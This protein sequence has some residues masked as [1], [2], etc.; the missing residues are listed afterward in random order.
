V[1]GTLH[2]KDAYAQFISAYADITGL[3]EGDAQAQ[4][5]AFSSRLSD[6]ARTKIEAGGGE[7]G[8][9]EG[10]LYKATWP[11][12]RGPIHD[13]LRYTFDEMREW[14]EQGF[15]EEE[16]HKALLLEDEI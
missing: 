8:R 9:R 11:N 3:T 10:A 13:H 4:W 5:R 6:Y 2:P 7:T 16:I 14:D 12:L 15:T 1:N